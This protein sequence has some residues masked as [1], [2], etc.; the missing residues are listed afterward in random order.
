VALLGVKH[1]IDAADAV[2]RAQSARDTYRTHLALSVAHPEFAEPE[3][4]CALINGPKSGAY[5]AFVD[6]LLY[7]AEQMLDVGEGWEATFTEA[8]DP[9]VTYICNGYGPHDSTDKVDTLI[10][11][12]K[13]ANCEMATECS[14]KNP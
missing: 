13:T 11:R 9:H 2:Q 5:A 6:H 4:A 1:Q 10:R 3:E 7:S 14:S 12:F 8:L